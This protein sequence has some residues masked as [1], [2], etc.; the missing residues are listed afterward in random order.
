MDVHVKVA[1]WLRILW[2]AMGLAPALLLLFVFGG[3][4]VV[5]SI[6]GG[7]PVAAPFIMV[8]FSLLSLLFLVT[9]LPGLITGWALLSYQSWARYVNVALSAFD[10]FNFPFGTALGVYSIWAMLSPESAALFE[11]G[12]VPGRYP[13]HF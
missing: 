9:A 10:L 3:I 11:P 12:G 7:A 13:Q 2:S 8:L 1:A 4:G 5:G 6:L